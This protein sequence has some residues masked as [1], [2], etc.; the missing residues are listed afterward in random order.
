MPSNS[1]F[2]TGTNASGIACGQ[3]GDRPR[4]THTHLPTP[5]TPRSLS[6]TYAHAA[7]PDILHPLLLTQHVME[8]GEEVSSGDVSRCHKE[9]I[10]VSTWQG[11]RGILHTILF[12]RPP[13]LSNTTFDFNTVANR[14]Y[15]KMYTLVSPGQCGYVYAMFVLLIATSLIQFFTST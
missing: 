3:K 1:I 15:S 6:H 12:Q 4:L 14:Y 13:S 7:H 5:Y 8:G 2:N 11:Q 9:R 10:N